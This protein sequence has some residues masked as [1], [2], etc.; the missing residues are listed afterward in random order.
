MINS[1]QYEGMTT[2]KDFF[3]YK[4]LVKTRSR[5]YRLMLN[6]TFAWFGQFS[7]NKYV[8]KLL[9]RLAVNREIPRLTLLSSIVSYYLPMMLT[10]V[11]ITDV[12]MKLLLNIIYALDG[13]IFA[14][15]GTRF[16][17]VIGRRKMFMISTMGMAVALSITAGT[18][19]DFVHTKSKTAS[20][21]S[22][23]FIYVFGGIFAFAFTS[24]QP[25][26]PTEVMTNDM[27]AKGAQSYKLISGASGFLNTFVGPIALTNVRCSTPS[28]PY[29]SPSTVSAMQD[30]EQ[31]P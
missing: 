11:G 6:V 20:S 5:R 7:G 17:D 21:A 23:A 29:S 2:W 26:Y 18:A 4:A 31:Y 22:I 10:N 15:I 9:P 1:L 8:S 3:N 24:M 30:I 14:T 12:N 13:W 25:I 16:H 28:P 19:A 27:R